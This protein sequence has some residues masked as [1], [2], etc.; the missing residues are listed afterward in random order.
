MN[1]GWYLYVDKECTDGVPIVVRVYDV[2]DYDLHSHSADEAEQIRSSLR[3][4]KAKHGFDFKEFN[5][6]YCEG[7]VR[8]ALSWDNADCKHDASA[9][10]SETPIELPSPYNC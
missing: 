4:F 10:W 8:F 3:D 5:V 1:Q 2:T 6:D 7:D 9:F